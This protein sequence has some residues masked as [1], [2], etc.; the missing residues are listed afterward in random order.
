MVTLV[1]VIRVGSEKGSLTKTGCGSAFFGCWCRITLTGVRGFG[2]RRCVSR[3]GCAGGLA[4]AKVFDMGS[5][6]AD[7]L[8]IMGLIFRARPT[9]KTAAASN[10]PFP[11]NGREGRYC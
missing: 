3:T 11:G 7:R 5:V 8:E 9:R 1:P 2:M 10:Q 4:G 6:W